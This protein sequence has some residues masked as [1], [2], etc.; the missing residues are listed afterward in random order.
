MKSLVLE[1][2]WEAMKPETKVSDLLR[3]ALVV[4][5]KLN[6]GEFR[7]WI[8]QEL[9][10]YKGDADSIPKYRH[11][12]CE[13]K[14]THPMYGLVPAVIGDAKLEEKLSILPNNQPIGELE[15]LSRD[16]DS[17]S[18]MQ[19]PLP[20]DIARQLNSESFA[21]GI[22]PTRVIGQAKVHGIVE[23][24]RNIVL[25][26]SLKLE[27]DG[28]LGEGLT[29]SKE[30][31]DKAASATYHIHNFTGVVGTVHTSMLQ[32]GGYNSI[33]TEL[34]NLGIP[35]PDRANL[36]NIMDRVQDAKGDEKVNLIRQ[37]LEWVLAHGSQLG[38]LAEL[39][40]RWFESQ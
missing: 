22:I 24:V 37:G 2:Q 33:H 12:K 28:I 25:E 15:H 23:S 16:R 35:Q 6:V 20:G 18:T 17:G 10:G 3:K 34:K 26:W 30:E 40:R 7:G 13:L 39:I 11:I 38:T 19:A 8:E 1:L 5:T 21:L 27:A 9:H 4:A 14:A 36:E 31:K 29:F 32:I